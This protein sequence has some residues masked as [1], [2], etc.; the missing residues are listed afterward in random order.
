[1]PQVRFVK[2][3]RQEKI[4]QLC[5]LAEQFFQQGMR[6]LLLVHDENQAVSLDRFLWTWN[7][8]SFLPHAFDSGSVE[9]FQEPIVVTI[10]ETNSNGAEVLI[11]GAPCSHEFLLQFKIVIDFAELYDPLLADQSRSRYRFYRDLGLNPQMY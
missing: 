5:E 11:L 8:G 2:L 3:E 9:C 10:Q 7:K 4:Q 1:M 6:V